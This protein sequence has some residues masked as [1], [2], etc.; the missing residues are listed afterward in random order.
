MSPRERPPKRQVPSVYERFVP[1]ILV[2]IVVL[3]LVLSVVTIAVLFGL[4]PG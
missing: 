3:M 2:I 4:W 1:I